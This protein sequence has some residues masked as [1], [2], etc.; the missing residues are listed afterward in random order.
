M[1]KTTFIINFYLLFYVLI[2]FL[3]SSM[4][5][6]FG[7][8]ILTSSGILL[9]SQ[10]LAFSWPNKTQTSEHNPVMLTFTYFPKQFTQPNSLNNL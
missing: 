2:L 9:N 10:I 8:G 5:K 1:E 4:N 3:C 6:P 7:S